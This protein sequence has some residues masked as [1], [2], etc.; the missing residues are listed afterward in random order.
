M[1]DASVRVAITADDQSAAAI[2][3]AQARI[4]A[5]KAA[6]ESAGNGLSYS[7]QVVGTTFV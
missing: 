6:S 4:A 1:P 2:S 7:M 5:F 3:A